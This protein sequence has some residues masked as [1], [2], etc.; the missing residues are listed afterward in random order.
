MPVYQYRGRRSDGALAEGELESSSSSV[1][2]GQLMERGIIPL[3]ISEKKHKVD[4]LEQLATR[5]NLRKVSVEELLMFTRQM[6]ALAK[7]GIPITRAISGILESVHNPLMIKALQD[8][9]EQLEAGRPLSIAFARHPKVFSNLYI[10]MIQ[11]GENTGNLDQAF[12]LMAGYIDRNRQMSNNI[13]AA[14]RYPTIVIVAIVIALAIVNLFVIP[15]FAQ[16]FQANHLV[17]PW[18]TVLLLN[19]SKFFVA[20]W[21][22]LLTGLILAWFSIVR[23]TATQQGR[24]K[25]HRLLLRLP[26]IGDIL[27]RAFLARFA[28]SFSM[29]YGAGVPIVQ[30]MGVISRSIGN[31]YI[32]DHVANMRE[33][34]ERGET[35]TITANRTG[36]F[37]PV[38]MQMF[39]VGEE[40]GNLEEMMSYIADFYEQ[41][42]DY[43]V[44]TLSD[45]LEPLIYVFVGALVLILALGIFVPMWDIAQLAHR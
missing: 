6:S 13:S 20:Y 16:F 31:D 44:K 24:Y 33:G 37:T 26:L 41:E 45:R 32:A 17:L 14:L 40:A 18:Q 1:V 15:K 11:V 8:S 3:T 38:V 12:A 29:A 36:M 30:G 4:V 23:Y 39:A 9:L 35:L 34:I 5:L 21:P 28:R 25:W 2:A 22:Y 42:V 7:A 10:S 19:T 27:L 43:D